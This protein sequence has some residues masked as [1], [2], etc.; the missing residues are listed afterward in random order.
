MPVGSVMTIKGDEEGGKWV[1]SGVE[2]FLGGQ[3]CLSRYVMYL[4]V[5]YLES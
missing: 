2:L 4:V 1:V 5:P 3:G